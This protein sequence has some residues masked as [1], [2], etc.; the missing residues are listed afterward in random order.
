MILVWLDDWPSNS[1]TPYLFFDSVTGPVF[2]LLG[3]WNRV[4]P[5]IVVLSIVEIIKE[6]V[7]HS[8]LLLPHIIHEFPTM[9]RR[10]WFTLGYSFRILFTITYGGDLPIGEGIP[11]LKPNSLYITHSRI[12]IASARIHPIGWL[13]CQSSKDMWH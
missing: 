2:K 8:W 7:N 12:Q 4:N 9:L 10:S 5:T 13:I 1:S 3:L 6:H 11:V